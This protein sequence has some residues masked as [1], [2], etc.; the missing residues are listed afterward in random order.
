MG[1]KQLLY[2]LQSFLTM[3]ICILPEFSFQKKLKSEN[4]KYRGHYICVEHPVIYKVLSMYFI[5]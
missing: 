5:N 1:E 4:M 2:E 3:S